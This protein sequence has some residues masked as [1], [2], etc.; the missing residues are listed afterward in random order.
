ME[1]VEQIHFV[2]NGQ[3]VGNSINNIFTTNLI[4][5]FTYVRQHNKAPLSNNFA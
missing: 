5:V 3:Y 2:E 4:Y 1:M